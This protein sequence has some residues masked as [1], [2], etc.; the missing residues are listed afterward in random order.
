MLI[1]I[2]P[3]W[4]VVLNVIGIPSA[5]LGIS[6]LCSKLPESFF[7]KT[8]PRLASKTEIHCYEKIFHVRKWNKSLPDA[9]P[10]FGGFSKAKLTSHQPGYLRKFSAETR[11][12]EL[13]HWIQMI[14]IMTFVIWNP[15]PAYLVIIIYAIV[16]N[17]PCIIS[18]RYARARINRLLT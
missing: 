12:G 6:W 16:S 7:Y 14:V 15:W 1:E 17:M 13:S 3:L 11:R 5:H 8:K 9:A 2:P 10:W 18:L 4:I